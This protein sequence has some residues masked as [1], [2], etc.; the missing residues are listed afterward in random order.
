MVY[1][2]KC[3]KTE[4]STA[5]QSGRL[6]ITGGNMEVGRRALL[7]F[8]IDKPREKYVDER[9]RQDE[10]LKKSKQRRSKKKNT[11]VNFSRVV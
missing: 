10:N 4:S 2:T 6:E 11:F 7:F 8:Y 9:E 5:A 1:K 3:R